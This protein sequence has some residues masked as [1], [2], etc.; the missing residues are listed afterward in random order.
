MFMFIID[1][2]KRKPTKYG[3]SDYHVPTIAHAGYNVTNK[4]R[5][6]LLKIGSN[7]CLYDG[8]CFDSEYMK[9]YEYLHPI[10]KQ[11]YVRIGNRCIFGGNT[12]LMM[13]RRRPLTKFIVY[14]IYYI[15]MGIEKL[16]LKIQE[17]WDPNC[18]DITNEFEVKFFIDAKRAFKILEMQ[19]YP[20]W[21][22]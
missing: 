22:K 3:D 6:E 5:H 11:D 13:Q 16:P 18:V 7:V 10:N 19:C 15:F 12:Y 17:I 14:S 9:L 20:G 21:K 8:R 1:G 2:Y 4:Y